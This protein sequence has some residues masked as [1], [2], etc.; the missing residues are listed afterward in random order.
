MSRNK[1]SYYVLVF[2]DDGPVYVTGVR[3]YNIAEWNKF[4]NPKSF[5][6]EYAQDIVK[7]LTWSGFNCQ[8][9]I[10]EWDIAHQ[11]YNYEKYQAVFV[12]RK[13]NE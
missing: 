8:V 7:G 11:P 1:Y 12:N 13:E 3:G 2:T 4:E 5:S 10:S 9:V 6:K